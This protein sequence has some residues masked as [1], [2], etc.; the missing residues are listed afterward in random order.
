MRMTFSRLAPVAALACALALPSAALATATNKQ[1]KAATSA[2]AAYLASQQQPDGSFSGFGGEWTLSALSAA[3]V[4]PAGVKAGP[5]D[6]DARTYYRSL[7]GDTTTWPGEG[8]PAVTT[9]ENA[10]LA[11]YGAGI[12]PARV[13]STQNL[14]A[15]IASYYQPS[16]PG[17]Y[18]EAG[19]FNGTAFALLALADAKTRTGKQRVPQALL[20]QSIEVVRHNQHSDGGWTFAQAEGDK[21]ALESPSEAEFTGASMAA[22]CDAGVPS[23][24]PAVSAPVKYLASDLAAEAADS[25][26]FAT[27]FGPNTD[28]NAWAVQ[29]LNACG[30]SAQGSQFTTS[31]GK[32]PIDYL[33]SQQ[34]PGGGFTYQSEATPNLYSSQDAVRA[35]AGAGFT[36][37][38]PAAKGAPRW[39]YEKGFDTSPG[40]SGLLTLVIDNGTPSLDVCAV[41]IAPQAVKT[42]LAK[43]LE[44][45][46]TAAKPS[47]CVSGFTPASGNGPI[48]SIDGAPSPAGP[49]WSV[50]IDGGRERPAKR[51]SPIHVGDTIYLRLS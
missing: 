5:G 10:A 3:R 6:T 12:D 32:T 45:A 49:G 46:E 22:L 44:A 16:H 40:V 17:F 21:A 30:I 51:S 38:P 27:E 33:I 43:V 48:T 39:V 26:A 8:E 35:L 42:T 7:V 14:I 19:L 31:T 34:L 24:D 41:S 15:Q 28:T 37:A 9:F 11:A 4:A 2:G 36:A 13:S 29:G 20:D 25:G 1:V 18:G 47:G 23:S 50:S